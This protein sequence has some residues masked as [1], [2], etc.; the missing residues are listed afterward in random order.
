LSSAMAM[1][2]QQGEGVKQ[3]CITDVTSFELESL[4]CDDDDVGLM[5]RPFVS[6]MDCLCRNFGS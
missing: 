3:N 2:I 4:L 6:V 5:E 1:N